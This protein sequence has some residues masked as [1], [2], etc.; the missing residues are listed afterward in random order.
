MDQPLVPFTILSPKVNIYCFGDLYQ[1]SQGLPGSF[2]TIHLVSL[3]DDDLPREM[4][5]P[6]T[7]SHYYIFPQR[8][9]IYCFGDLHQQSQ[10]L[11]RSFQTI[12]L[13]PLLGNTLVRET[14][15]FQTGH[16]VPLVYNSLIKDIVLDR[17]W[18]PYQVPSHKRNYFVLDWSLGQI[19]IQFL[20]E[21]YCFW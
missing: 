18:S 7:W 19:N 2:Q 8:K 10:G 21:R 1:Q 12:L 5:R 16:W 9:Y 14:T 15:L 11:S 17:F 13:V 3:T 4:S 6:V 20:K